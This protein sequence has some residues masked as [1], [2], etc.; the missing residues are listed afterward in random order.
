MYSSLMSSMKYDEARKVLRKSHGLKKFPELT[1][2]QL[3][4][5]SQPKT[6]LAQVNTLTSDLP[7]LR[8]I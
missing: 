1:V 6:P 4:S 8:I 7:L 3:L 5:S 2:A